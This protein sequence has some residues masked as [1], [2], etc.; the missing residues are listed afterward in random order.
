MD[1]GFIIFGN[2]VYIEIFIV[3][4]DIHGL[5][6]IKTIISAGVP[7]VSKRTDHFKSSS[8]TGTFL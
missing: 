7:T 3:L 6:A 4:P 1:V 5:D 2:R 8:N